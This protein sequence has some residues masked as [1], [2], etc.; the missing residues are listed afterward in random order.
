M[1][2]LNRWHTKIRIKMHF[3]II[4]NYHL[5]LFTNLKVMSHIY[6]CICPILYVSSQPSC[7]CKASVRVVPQQCRD[8]RK[9]PAVLKHSFELGVCIQV[10]YCNRVVA[11]FTPCYDAY[12]LKTGWR[13]ELRTYNMICCLTTETDLA[14]PLTAW[15]NPS[16]AEGWWAGLGN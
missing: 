5:A 11:Y 10:N 15:S 3:C 13:G 16:T 4:N 14:S 9:Q 12:V 2:V 6:R 7:R 8:I 1:Y